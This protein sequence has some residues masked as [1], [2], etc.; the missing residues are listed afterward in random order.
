MYTQ[1]YG[2]TEKPF[3][4]TPDPKFL[5]LTAAH[6]EALASMMYG[7]TERRGYIAITGEVGTGKTTL[8][9]TLLNQL[10]DKVR[11]VCVFHTAVTFEQLL[12][13][14]LA[15]LNLPCDGSKD[16]L[17][18]DFKTYLRERLAQDEIIALIIDEAQNLSR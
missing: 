9:Y 17:L 15:E 3:N 2:F 7:I 13:T 10:S 4:V 1:F 16:E 12:R 11:A 14:I 8:I 18:R 6:R 5:Y